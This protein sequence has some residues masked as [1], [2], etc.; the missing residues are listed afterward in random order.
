MCVA[1]QVRIIVCLLR[2]DVNGSFYLDAKKAAY[3]AWYKTLQ[4]C[5]QAPCKFRAS[6]VQVPCRCNAKALHKKVQCFCD[7]RAY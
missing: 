4:V 2:F 1:E 5:V 3:V 6:S 7:A